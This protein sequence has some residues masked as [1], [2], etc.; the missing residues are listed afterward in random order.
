M[1]HYHDSAAGLATRDIR[2]IHEQSQLTGNTTQQ[3]INVGHMQLNPY[4]A[5]LTLNLMFNHIDHKSLHKSVHTWDGNIDNANKFFSQLED[6][7]SS[8]GLLA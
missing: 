8:C 3:D 6:Y 7:C 4:S 5:P 1:S 2:H